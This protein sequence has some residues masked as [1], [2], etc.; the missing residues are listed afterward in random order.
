MKKEYQDL[1]DQAAGRSTTDLEF[2]TKLLKDAP[3]LIQ[4][5][6]SKELPFQVTFH[7]SSEKNLVFILPPSEEE[8]LNFDDLDQ[9]TGGSSVHGMT[10][11]YGLIPPAY[12]R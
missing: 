7:E 6:Y 10:L 2:R 1:L 5:E 9:V 12:R 3:A 11:A 4:N 8:E